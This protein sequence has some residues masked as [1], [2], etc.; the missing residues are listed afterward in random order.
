MVERR[1][2]DLDLPGGGAI[3]IRGDDRVQQLQLDPPQQVLVLFAKVLTFGDEAARPF[4]ALEIVRIQPGELLPHLQVAEIVRGES[5]GG[6]PQVGG[7][8]GPSPPRQQ[9]RIAGI[10]V[11]HPVTLCMEKI[12]QDEDSVVQG[13]RIGLSEAEFEVAI[14]RAGRGKRLDLDEHRRDEVEGHADTGK[15]VQERYHP[16]VVLQRM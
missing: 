2:R 3:A 16:V 13:E 4:V 6:R 8:H 10:R 9:L 14:V 12:L 15:L 11:D 1:G 7:Q 5:S